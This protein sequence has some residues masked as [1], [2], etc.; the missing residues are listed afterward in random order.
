MQLKPKIEKKGNKNKKG[1]I[2]EWRHKKQE[3]Q[4]NRAKSLKNRM[5]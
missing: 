1:F 4:N 3:M 5:A 2:E